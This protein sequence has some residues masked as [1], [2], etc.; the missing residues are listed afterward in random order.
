M[1]D[2]IVIWK[3]EVKHGI[4]LIPAQSTIIK[5]TQVN[6]AVFVW[7]AVN[8]TEHKRTG[9]KMIEG[10]KAFHTGEPIQE[11]LNHFKYYDTI[12][13]HSGSYVLH[14]MVNKNHFA[15]PNNLI[16]R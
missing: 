14:I 7:A 5:V 12:I 6:N 15:L 2:T 9:E 4:T 8:F 3:Y 13:L 1:N 10:I 16:V 11:N